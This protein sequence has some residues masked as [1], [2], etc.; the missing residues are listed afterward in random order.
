VLRA[1]SVRGRRVPDDLSVISTGDTDLA[2]LA[3]P[4][5]TV[6]RWDLDLLGREAATLLLD[7][8]AGPAGA[9]EAKHLQVPTEVVLRRSCA[10]RSGD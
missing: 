6:I 9:Y 5:F 2:E 4:S 8:L 7:R 10:P 3:P 1:T